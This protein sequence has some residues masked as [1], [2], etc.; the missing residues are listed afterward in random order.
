M[1]ASPRIHSSVVFKQLAI[2][3]CPLSSSPLAAFDS[4]LVSFADN[5]T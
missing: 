5:G 4:G 2:T 1:L 3:S